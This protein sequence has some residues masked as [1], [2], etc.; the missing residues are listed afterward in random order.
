MFDN[1]E[2]FWYWVAPTREKFGTLSKSS[3]LL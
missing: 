2:L 3:E 1:P